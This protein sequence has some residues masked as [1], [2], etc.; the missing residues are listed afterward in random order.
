LP[1]L[2]E[3][4]WLKPVESLG[5][6]QGA[7]A[8][9]SLRKDSGKGKSKYGDSGCARMTNKNKQRPMR[10]FFA[11]LRMTNKGQQQSYLLAR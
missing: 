9:C 8:P 4:P 2:K 10:G 5:F 11:A 7:E 6:F 3:G 1:L